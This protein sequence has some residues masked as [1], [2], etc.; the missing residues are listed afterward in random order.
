MTTAPTS[1]PSTL[2]PTRTARLTGAAANYIDERTSISGI[3]KE[4]GRKIFPDHWSFMLGEVALYSFVV[5]LL[6]GTWLT[7]FFQPS[8]AEVHYEGSYV[9]L[10]GLEMSIA[11]ASALDISFDIR[12]GLLMR[13]MH[14]WAALL[15]IAAIGLHMLRVFFTGAFRKPREINWFVGF[16]LFILA[17]AEGFT[18]YSLPDDL[19]SGNGLRI[20]DGMVKAIPI[21]GVWISYLLFGGEFP[22]TDVVA[23]FYS[24]HILLLPAVLVAALGVHMLLLIINKHTQFAGPGKTNDNVVGVPIMPVFAAKAGGFFFIVFGVLTVIAAFFTINPIWNYGPYDPS[25]V[26][27]GT[28]PDWYIGFADGALR[29]V[30]P[31]LE[32]VI[33]GYVFSWNILLPLGVLPLFLGAV[34]FY[35]WLEAWITGDKREHHIADRPRNAPVRTAIGAAGVTFYAVLWAAASSDLIAT[36]FGLGIEMVIHTLQ[37]LLFIGPVVAFMLTRRICL[38]LQRKD[39]EIALHGFESGRIV[40]LPGG[41]YIEVHEQVD[42]YERWK[43]LAYDDYQPLML[44]PNARGQITV[45]ERIRSRLSGWFYEDRIS[46]VNQRELEESSHH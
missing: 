5:I 42:E 31:H 9:P 2:P 45:G 22:G 29:L 25:P 39:R 43:L 41:E 3:V 24:L 4:L 36:H 20:I 13:Q 11:Y 18:G 8:M 26:S 15:F 40:R 38:G 27:A 6:S 23:R 33:F 35:P 34:A 14:H 1:T 28:Q 21:I 7:F 30:P 44:R 10:K 12:G 46:P 32:T 16:V 17:M 19:L 37:A